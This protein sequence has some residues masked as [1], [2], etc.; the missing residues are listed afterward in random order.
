[1]MSFTI[2]TLHEITSGLRLTGNAARRGEMKMHIKLLRKP[3]GNTT[4][5]KYAK[6]KS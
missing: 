2:C 3:H 5:R 4:W 6:M 1:M